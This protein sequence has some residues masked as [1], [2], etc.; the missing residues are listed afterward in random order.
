MPARDCPCTARV[1]DEHQNHRN[2]RRVVSLQPV[3][4]PSQRLIQPLARDGVAHYRHRHRSGGNQDEDHQRG[5][6]PGGSQARGAELQTGCEADEEHLG[7]DDRQQCPGTAGPCRRDGAD[8]PQPGRRMR[9][10]AASAPAPDPD[11]D[12]RQTERDAQP[13]CPR[14]GPVQAATHQSDNPTNATVTAASPTTHPARKPKPAGL[15]RGVCKTSTAGMTN[16]GDSATTSASG[17]SSASTEPQPSATCAFPGAAQHASTEKPNSGGHQPLNNGSGG[18]DSPVSS[19]AGQ[20]VV[21]RAEIT[22][23]GDRMAIKVATPIP[24]PAP[25]PRG[26]G[27]YR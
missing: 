25:I 13:R 24:A 12:E 17:T 14:R 11:H 15:G 23:Q 4:E 16:S 6:G 22:S 5:P 10:A 27:R 20:I 3:L 8:R 7:T 21:T 18:G 26:L 2:Q 9:R 19:A 1:S